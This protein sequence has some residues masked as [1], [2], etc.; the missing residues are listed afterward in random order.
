MLKSLNLPVPLVLPADFMADESMYDTLPLKE[1]RTLLTADYR[2]L[3]FL[4]LS[5]SW[6]PAAAARLLLA[7]LSQ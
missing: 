7:G 3:I 5:T 4:E 2:L 1:V 6:L